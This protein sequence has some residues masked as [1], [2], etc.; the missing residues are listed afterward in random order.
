VLS[1]S[2]SLAILF[3]TKASRIVSEEISYQKAQRTLQHRLEIERDEVIHSILD[4]MYAN[5]PYT[6]I[7]GAMH[8]PSDRHGID[9]D[10]LT[11]LKLLG[12]IT[13]SRLTIDASGLNISVKM[14]NLHK[15]S[16]VICSRSSTDRTEV[17]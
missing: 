17:S 12:R 5:A 11:E 7:Q 2:K 9:P 10:L 6:V 16:T 13:H 1:D 3:Q 15:S 4:M 14:A 8:I